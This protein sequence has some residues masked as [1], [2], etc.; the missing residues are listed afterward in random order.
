MIVYDNVSDSDYT[1][2]AGDRIAQ[3]WVE[4][5]YRFK[6]QIVDILPDAAERGQAGFG[7]TG[8]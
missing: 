2:N 1:V 5:I 3:M 7:S 8:K 6:P 4:P